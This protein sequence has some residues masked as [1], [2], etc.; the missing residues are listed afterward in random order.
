MRG[1]KIRRRR[2][3]ALAACGAG[4]APSTFAEDGNPRWDFLQTN[5]QV[6][7]GT[8]K[9]FEPDPILFW[10]LRANLRRVKA[11]ERLPQSSHKFRV[12]TDR[13]GRRVTKSVDGA[14]R[15]VLFLGDSCT[16]GIPVNDDEAF[17]EQVQSS[18]DGVRCVNAGVPGYS[19]FQGRIQLEQVLKVDKPD[20]AVVT[21]WPNGRTVWDHLSDAEHLELLE[22]ER[23][24]E[25]S[26]HRLSRLLRRAMPGE[27]QRLNDE[28]FEAEIRRMIE[29]CRQAGTTPIL[30][31]W[32]AQAQMTKELAVGRQS[33]LRRVGRETEVRVVDQVEPFRRAGGEKLF[34]DPVHATAEGYRVAADGLTPSIVEALGA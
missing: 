7:P 24:D 13:A 3:L 15:T 34:V 25:F 21:F 18:L 28:E 9:L 31:V 29:L 8:E 17:P 19:A 10:K 14:N 20:V 33:I 1:D 30:Q 22:A 12:S 4:A 11:E 2:F 16:F 6:F 26:R 23:N 27:R 5:L 32:P